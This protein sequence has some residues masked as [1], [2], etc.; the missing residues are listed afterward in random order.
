VRCW[1]RRE[2]VGAVTA[3]PELCSRCASNIDGP[4]EQRRYV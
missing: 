3:H 1:Q 4:G 2:D